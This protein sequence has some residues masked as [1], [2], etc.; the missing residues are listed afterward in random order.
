MD[1][2]KIHALDEAVVQAS[3]KIKVLNALAWP[4]G[5][6]EKFLDDWRRGNPQLPKIKL[7]VPDVRDSVKALDAIVQK[8]STPEFGNGISFTCEPN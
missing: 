8:S 1:A 2:Q 6:E 5:V 4:N 3:K 7:L